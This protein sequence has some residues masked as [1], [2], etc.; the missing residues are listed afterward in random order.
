MNLI[1]FNQFRCL[2]FKHIFPLIIRKNQY[3]QTYF[4]WIKWLILKQIF[5]FLN[6]WLS[7][8]VSRVCCLCGSACL[9][10]HLFHLLCNELWN[11]FGSFSLLLHQ[12]SWFDGCLIALSGDLH[13]TFCYLFV[14]MFYIGER[15]F[16]GFG[17]C[18]FRWW[19]AFVWLLL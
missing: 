1:L 6:L 4:P 11:L 16:G 2:H 8:L 17:C 19:T 18:C 3:F 7:V 10:C 14:K 13:I 5:C 9:L 15:G 12:F